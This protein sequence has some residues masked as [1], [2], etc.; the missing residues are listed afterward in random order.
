M[1]K[2]EFVARIKQFAYYDNIPMWTVSEN[3]EDKA[4]FD[5]SGELIKVKGHRTYLSIDDITELVFERGD[6]PTDARVKMYYKYGYIK[7]VANEGIYSIDM[8]LNG[9][10]RY[11]WKKP[12]LAI[13]EAL[14]YAKDQG[15]DLQS[16]R[17]I[18]RDDE[19]LFYTGNHLGEVV[20]VPDYIEVIGISAFSQTSV[21]KVILPEGLKIVGESCFLSCSDLEE[22][23]LP[24][25]LLVIDGAAFYRCRTLKE[26]RIPDGVEQIQDSFFSP[27]PRGVFEGCTNLSKVEMSNIKDRTDLNTFKDTKFAENFTD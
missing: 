14:A 8:F 22:V 19:L 18:I 12:A 5:I 24:E 23:N 1:E 17:L 15:Q 13:S 20:E 27:K 9:E 11:F 21:K 25:S 7:V 26:I 2:R 16:E 6:C 3:P 10:K 4:Y